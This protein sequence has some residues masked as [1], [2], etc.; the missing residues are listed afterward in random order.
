MRLLT[1]TFW[2]S[3]WVWCK[4]NWKFLV[5]VIIPVAIGIL[6]RKNKQGD[7][8]KNGLELRKNQ[9]SIEKDAS[10]TEMKTKEEAM[11]SFISE[12]SKLDEDH[13][14]DLKDIEANRK[15]SINDL[16][17]AEKV[18]EEINNRLKE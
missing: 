3:V 10:E 1:L 13:K 2:K 14:S 12:N 11:K 8:L 15:D 4:I 7:V 16:S 5:G 18:T 9:L 6:L 17:S